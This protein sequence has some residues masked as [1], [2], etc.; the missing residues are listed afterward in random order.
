MLVDDM[1]KTFYR[2]DIYHE[3]LVHIIIVQIFIVLKKAPPHLPIS[4]LDEFIIDVVAEEVIDVEVEGAPC[5]PAYGPEG[6]RLSANAAG[7]KL[8]SLTF[9][10]KPVITS[11]AMLR[12]ANLV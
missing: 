8:R 10:S 2:H 7:F 6:P 9:L 3:G 1:H 5:P 12:T 11:T 4:L